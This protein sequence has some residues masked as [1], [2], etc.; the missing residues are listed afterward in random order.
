MKFEDLEERPL[1]TLRAAYE[2]LQLSGFED[3][4][5]KVVAYLDSIRSYEKNQHQLDDSSREKVSIRWRSTFER[6]GYDI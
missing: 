2:K 5:G 1:D 3:V 4:E 6:Y